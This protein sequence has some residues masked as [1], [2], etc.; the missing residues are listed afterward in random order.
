MR[1]QTL[2]KENLL[3]LK[4]AKQG[5]DLLHVEKDPALTSIPGRTRKDMLNITDMIPILH[6]HR[7][8]IFY[9]HARIV[10]NK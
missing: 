5:E 7:K 9:S 4:T 6:I 8:N 10:L 3:H 2:S 1:I